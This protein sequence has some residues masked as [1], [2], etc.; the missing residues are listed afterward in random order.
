MSLR[1]NLIDEFRRKHLSS[2]DFLQL[3]QVE[4]GAETAESYL[5]SQAQSGYLMVS[6]VEDE[7]LHGDAQFRQQRGSAQAPMPSKD[8]WQRN[9]RFHN[10]LCEQNQEHLPIRMGPGPGAAAAL[11]WLIP[12]PTAGKIIAAG[13]SQDCQLDERMREN[14]LLAWARR[15]IEHHT[16]ASRLLLQMPAL[17][18][19]YW[20]YK[21]YRGDLALGGS[22][23]THLRTLL[24]GLPRY[25]A[26]ESEEV[27]GPCQETGNAWPLLVNEP[28]DTYGKEEE[29]SDNHCELMA[30]LGRRY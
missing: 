28:A 6:L 10:W 1:F 13:F 14:W 12:A 8:F 7:V 9:I 21:A 5:A 25:G 20:F 26:S 18:P 16:T 15:I 19:A 29:R 23:H 11:V 17:G 30:L 2:K 22:P 4:L 3:P 27:L 24:Q